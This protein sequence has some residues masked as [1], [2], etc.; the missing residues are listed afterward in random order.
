MPFVPYKWALN[1]YRSRVNLTT[2]K[3]RPILFLP[4]LRTTSEAPRTP[5]R[6]LGLET[7]N[8]N[9]FP[10]PPGQKLPAKVKRLFK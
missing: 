2:V 1:A 10:I 3:L 5:I 7:D 6:P 9:L 8:H 4:W